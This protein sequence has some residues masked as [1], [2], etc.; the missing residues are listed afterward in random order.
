MAGYVPNAPQNETVV[1][2]LRV[3]YA[4]VPSAFNLLGM[5]I[6]LAYPIDG[7]IHGRIREAVARREQGQAFV[8]PLAAPPATK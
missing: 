6:A 5:A 2:T 3:L 8:D 1:W 7:G 4:L